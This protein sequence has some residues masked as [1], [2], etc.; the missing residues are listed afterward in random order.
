MEEGGKDAP[1]ILVIGGEGTGKS[2]LIRFEN[3]KIETIIKNLPTCVRLLL[4]KQSIGESK[5][6]YL[7]QGLMGHNNRLVKIVECPPR[8]QELLEAYTERM[9]QMVLKLHSPITCVI[10]VI[11]Q[12]TVGGGG[13]QLNRERNIPLDELRAAYSIMGNKFKTSIH[14]VFTNWSRQFAR[15]NDRLKRGVTEETAQNKIANEFQ[16]NLGIT[17]ISCYFMDTVFWRN[18]Q[19]TTDRGAMTTL[20]SSYTLAGSIFME[21]YDPVS[22]TSTPKTEQRFTSKKPPSVP[23]SK[24]QYQHYSDTSDSESESKKR[25][26]QW[27]GKKFNNLSLDSDN[28]Q[29]TDNVISRNIPIQREN[30]FDHNKNDEMIVRAEPANVVESPSATNKS[31]TKYNVNEFV[32]TKVREMMRDEGVVLDFTEAKLNGK[33][34]TKTKIIKEIIGKDGKVE[35]VEEE[36]MDES[37]FGPDMD[38]DN[39]I[40]NTSTNS[41]TSSRIQRDIMNSSKP[42]YSL[43]S[44]VVS[45]TFDRRKNYRWILLGL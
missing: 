37:M 42:I 15:Y 11:K 5:D 34:I 38:M 33:I 25:L 39:N 28:S 29:I 45:S 6:F 20:Q 43:G 19:R 32:E 23:K 30:G 22:N 9:Q 41:E 31:Y 10:V 7:H 26:S 44:P 24:P 1:N 36:E 18:E 2:S 8:R 21:P 16:R 40:V 13:F 3:I 14:V 27:K 12:N 35:Y 17:K 4:G